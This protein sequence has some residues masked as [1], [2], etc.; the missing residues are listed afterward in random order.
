MVSNKISF[1]K[2]RKKLLE[3]YH[4]REPTE[5]EV[6]QFLTRLWAQ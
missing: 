5:L 6:E 1:Q 2:Y 4:I 3:K